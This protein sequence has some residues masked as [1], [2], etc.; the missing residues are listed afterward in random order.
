ML[1]HNTLELEDIDQNSDRQSD[2]NLRKYQ[3]WISGPWHY[4]EFLS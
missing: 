1:L 4:S 2:W 3:V